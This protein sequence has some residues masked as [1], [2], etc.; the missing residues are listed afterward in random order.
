MGCGSPRCLKCGF[1][2][3]E[4]RD[5]SCGGRGLRFASPHVYPHR[6]DDGHEENRID[7]DADLAAEGQ[8]PLVSR[9]WWR[10]NV[11]LREYLGGDQC[12]ARHCGRRRWDQCGG[13]IRVARRLH[14][15][16]CRVD[17]IAT[18]VVSGGIE[19]S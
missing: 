12:Q 7:N 9:A 3:G 5:S 6:D 15:D 2:G 4:C 19:N 8:S 11:L 18:E 16:C 10:E 17:L 14:T 13:E 1:F